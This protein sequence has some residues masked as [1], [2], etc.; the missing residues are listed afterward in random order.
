MEN[1]DQIPRLVSKKPPV[2]HNGDKMC[3]TKNSISR[4]KLDVFYE[5]TS[6]IWSL[7]L[8][9]CGQDTVYGE[10]KATILVLGLL[11]VVGTVKKS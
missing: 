5:G 9:R 11:Q 10:I 4:C 2:C 6:K 1:L 7:N 3:R 8:S